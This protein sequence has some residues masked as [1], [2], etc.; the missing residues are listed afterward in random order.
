MR[1]TGFL[2]VKDSSIFIIQWVNWIDFSFEAEEAVLFILIDSRFVHRSFPMAW[3]GF[4]KTHSQFCNN[5]ITD[6]LYFSE[7]SCA[8]HIIPDLHNNLK[9]TQFQQHF[10]NEELVS[11]QCC[12]LPKVTELVNATL[13]RSPSL[14]YSEASVLHRPGQPDLRAGARVSGH[15]SPCRHQ[16]LV[17]SEDEWLSR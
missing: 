7:V 16:P 10:R 2:P 8:P 6:N 17:H 15:A 5:N 3:A 11:Q 4:L 9:G 14:S 1:T 12:Q 13:A